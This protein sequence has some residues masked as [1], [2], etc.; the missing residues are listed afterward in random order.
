MGPPPQH[1]R[2]VERNQAYQD[3][4]HL[5]QRQM[6]VEHE[7]DDGYGDNLA[8]D[9]NPAELDELPHVFQTR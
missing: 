3:Y 4:G 1:A 5:P 8:D 9:G 6:D 2:D 7:I